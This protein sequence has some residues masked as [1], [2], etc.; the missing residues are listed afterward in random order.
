MTPDQIIATLGLLL[1]EPDSAFDVLH[2]GG[3]DPQYPVTVEACPES[4]S[5]LDV[6]GHTVLCGTVSVPENYNDP[7]G[8]RIPLAFVLGKAFS[9]QPFADAIIYLHGGPASGA[10]GS[11][12][13]VT[14]VILGDHR[15]HRDV[16]SFDQRAAMLSSS[17]VR[18]YDAMAENIEGIVRSVEEVPPAEGQDPFDVSALFAPCVD[19]LYASG[20]D[21]TQYNT[22]NNAR[23]VRALMSALGYPEYNI[24]GISYGTKLALE[25]LRTAPEGV[26]AVILDGVAPPNVKLYDELFPPHADAIEALF[27][28]CAADDACSEAYPDLRSKFIELGETLAQNPIPASRGQVPITPDV[29]YGIVNLRTKLS[30]SWVRDLNNYLPRMIYELADGNPATFD[31]YLRSHA[32]PQEATPDAILGA[33]GARL[34]GDERAL[35]LAL[36]ESAQ[37]MMDQSE[38]VVAVLNQLKHDLVAGVETT[39]VAEAFDRRATEALIELPHTQA[40]AAIQDYVQFQAR[41]HSRETIAD[42]VQSHFSGRE[43]HALLDLISA[44]ADSDIA[45]T[46]EIAATDLSPYLEVVESQMGLLI[47]AC[48]E[49]WPYNSREGG[50]KVNDAFPYGV[51]LTEAAQVTLDGIYETCALFEPAP[52]TGF[53]EPVASDVP[54]L[55]IGGTNDT[56]TSWTW[57]GLAAETLTNARLLILP[58]S[59]H[60]ASLYSA[61]GRDINAKFILDPS[62]HLDFSCAVDLLPQFVMPD[63]PLG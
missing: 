1:S 17:T 3:Y 23:D 22:A 32:E 48:Q 29:F 14:E 37:A 6:E 44:M 12:Q 39:S 35:A 26:R 56:Q 58:N 47:Y 8:R 62:A 46:F 31:W 11:V 5:P 21:L 28:Q 41:E 61:C 15:I 42:W 38:G 18:C 25:V 63:D 2:D 16:V 24:F 33:G 57:S 45:R 27:D 30:Q 40:I 59:G 55:V 7:D 34:S 54:A 60:G 49:D 36:I 51:I 53:H 19:E 4:T 50:A 52:R 9:S 13:A 43:Q 10:L 20:A